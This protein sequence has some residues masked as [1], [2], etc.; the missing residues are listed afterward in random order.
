MAYVGAGW[1]LARTSLWLAWRLGPLDP[2]RRWLAVDDY[3]FH[4]GYLH[5]RSAIERQRCPQ[6]LRGHA[7]GVFDQGLGRSL[8]FV[9]GADI[10]VIASTLG[11]FPEN[12]R[13]DL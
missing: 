2:L 13:T 6:S 3:G 9:K 5:H 12:R 8:W 10:A 4:A 1:A 11:A 7:V